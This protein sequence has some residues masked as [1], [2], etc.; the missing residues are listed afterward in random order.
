MAPL[1][2]ITRVLILLFL[3][4]ACLTYAEEEPKEEKLEPVE[5][6]DSDASK[7]EEKPAVNGDEVKEEDDVLVLTANNFDGVIDKNNDILVEF[8][9]PWYV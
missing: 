8:Y 6:T 9:A 3:A 2:S 5:T 7:T 1:E 4:T